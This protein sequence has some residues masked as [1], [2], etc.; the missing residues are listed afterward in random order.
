MIK[1][2][3]VFFI[4]S[5]FFGALLAFGAGVVVATL[6]Y[7]LSAYFLKEK[8]SLYGASQVIRQVIQ[9]SFLLIIFVFGDRT[10]WD[11]TWLLIGG[12]IGVT[13][14]MIW[15]TFR[16]VKLNDSLHSEEES[17]DG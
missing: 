4:E 14:P 9:I 8:N 16:L 12:C 6:N 17:S 5:N 13:L 1:S 10:V 11:R 2:K 7:A 15:F 3:K